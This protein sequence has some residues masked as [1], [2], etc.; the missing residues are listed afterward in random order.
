MELVSGLGCVQLGRDCCCSYHIR[1]QLTRTSSPS[2]VASNVASRI[3]GGTSATTVTQ[4]RQISA[5]ES[6]MVPGRLRRKD[7][8]LRGLPGMQKPI[9]PCVN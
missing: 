9:T 5:Q 2:A 7:G 3:T 8:K 6:A 4:E 1:A